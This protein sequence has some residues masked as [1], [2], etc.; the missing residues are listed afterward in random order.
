MNPRKLKALVTVLVLT[1][2]VNLTAD[3]NTETSSKVDLFKNFF[4]EKTV[5]SK[6]IAEVCSQEGGS[7]SPSC[8]YVMVRS[9][10]NGFYYREVPRLDDLY[11]T[12]VFQ[13]L[14]FAGFYNDEYWNF[15]TD[16]MALQFSTNRSASLKKT[17][18]FVLVKS[19]SVLNL[20]L[21]DANPRSIVWNGNTVV[22]Y[23]NLFGVSFHGRLECSA[24]G[25]P[26]DFLLNTDFNGNQVSW[27]LLYFYEKTGEV[28]DYLP[29]RITAQ[30][31]GSGHSD[32]KFQV[33]FLVVEIGDRPLDKEYFMPAGFSSK[34]PHQ[35]LYGDKGIYTRNRLEKGFKPMPQASQRPASGARYVVISG[36]V[37]SSI[38]AFVISR[39]I[40]N[41]K[42]Q[43]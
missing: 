33:R 43:K 9:Q 22:P 21:F 35:L 14:R 27:K 20:G 29:T 41:T 18:D 5:I 8:Y 42:Q 2:A 17:L 38:I 23:T 15:S 30:T 12:N 39:R 11:S 26:V 37:L 13:N 1:F 10:A 28:P 31:V 4:D 7:N 19:S 36:L 25:D 6:C 34:P 16:G 32:F 3:G 24:S 40:N